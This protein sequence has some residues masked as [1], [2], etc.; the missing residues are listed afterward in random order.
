M[1]NL[2]GRV[3]KIGRRSNFKRMPRDLYRTF[4][5]RAVAALLPHLAP[6]TE[7]IEP[8]AGAYDLAAQLI[9]AGHIC[10]AASDIHPLTAGID[11][12]DALSI[13][14]QRF[15]IITNPP[16]SRPLLH[17][18]ILHFVTIAPEVWLLLDATW[19]HTE[20]AKALLKHCTDVVTIGRMNWVPG[21]T[22]RSKDDSCWYRFT[23]A[24]S[25]WVRAWP[26]R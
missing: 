24:E 10:M 15:A 18:M 25:E 3:I 11:Q 19:F 7:F 14:A 20:Q 12:A 5:P 1:A 13:T 23:R 2:Q 22:M 21:T 6:E 17:Q 8:C 9:A 26:K 16:W 4:D